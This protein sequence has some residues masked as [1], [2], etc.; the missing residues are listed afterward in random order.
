MIQALKL[1]LLFIVILFAAS[2]CNNNGS[3]SGPDQN[4]NVSFAITQQVTQTGSMQFMFKPV[5]DIKISTL[6]SK[7]PAEQFADTLNYGNPNYVYSKDTTYIINRY[8]NVY[9]GQQWVFEFKGTDPGSNS[10]YIKT[11]NYTVQ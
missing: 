2:G 10:Q 4:S 8:V 11:I 6:I 5:T 9:S 1:S 3:I 7:Y